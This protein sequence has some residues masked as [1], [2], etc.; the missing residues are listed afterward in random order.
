MANLPIL[1]LRLA[2]D[3]ATAPQFRAD[4]LAAA[5]EVGFFYLVGHGLDAVR[6]TELI[7]AAR[8]FFALPEQEKR[9]IENVNSPHFRGWTRVGGER[10]QGRTD[11]REQIDI[12]VEREPVAV[13]AGVPD[14]AV[15]EGPNLWPESLPGFRNVV[16]NWSAHVAGVGRQLLQ[17][18]AEALGQDRGVFDAAYERHMSLTKI[19]RYPGRVE[20]GTEQGVGAHKDSGMLTLLFVEPGKGGLQVEG[21]DGWV[22]ATPVEGAFIVNIGELLEVATDGYLVATN[23]RVVAPPAGDERISVPFFYNPGLDARIPKLTLPPEL[24][25]RTRGVTQDASNV[26]F[27]TYGANALKSRLRAHPDV[28]ARHHQRLLVSA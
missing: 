15:L 23:H 2:A 18:W 19:V 16:E 7:N 4:L 3:P 1:D 20:G 17:E 9:A 12:T 24:A 22:D 26:I 13:G 27:D 5:H 28:A 10:T 25:A 11:W 21:P 14:W 6:Q 8:L